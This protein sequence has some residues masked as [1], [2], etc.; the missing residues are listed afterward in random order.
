MRKT[1]YA[2]F[3]VVGGFL[4]ALLNGEI[5]HA[6]V[7]DLTSNDTTLWR[8]VTTPGSST[9]LVDTG[10]KGIV[11]PVDGRGDSQTG[12]TV[13][14]LVGNT[15]S[16]T[17]LMA[18]GTI[19]SVDYIGFRVR[20]DTFSTLDALKQVTYI[21]FD[22]D[23]P[24]TTGYGNAD[25]FVGFD[26]KT[27]VPNNKPASDY[28]RVIISDTDPT[29]TNISPSTTG[30]Y[31]DGTVASALYALPSSGADSY[32]NYRQADT[33]IGGTADAFLSFAVPYSS[34]V[35]AITAAGVTIS[36]GFN[37][38]T[39]YRITAATSNTEQL[40]NQDAMADMDVVFNF[41]SPVSTSGTP[42]PEPSTALA[43]A[44]MV[45][46]AFVTVGYRRRRKHA[47]S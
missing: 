24:G 19:G 26:V 34:F 6:A 30:I 27:Q 12:Q 23:Q 22:F 18:Y 39:T 29:K 42:I 9:Y 33:S 2:T 45:L 47:C 44:V 38:N 37:T 43:L 17:L 35:S 40:L 5:S 25:M 31:Y 46:P 8:G 10:G 32:A 41:S 4:V 28:W 20:L 21:G 15:T 16:P 7:L 36:G 1:P 13:A 11:N 3:S 14:D